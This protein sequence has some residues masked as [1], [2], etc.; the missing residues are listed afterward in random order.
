M[1]RKSHHYSRDGNGR[2]VYLLSNVTAK[3]NA[4]GSLMIRAFD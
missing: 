3:K 1:S 2:K 4:D